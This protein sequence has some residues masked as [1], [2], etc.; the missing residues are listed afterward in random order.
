MGLPSAVL[1]EEP[2]P[3]AAPGGAADRHSA[4]GRR[5]GFVSRE[6]I[7]GNMATG[8][9]PF[10]EVMHDQDLPNWS[11]DSVDDR[12]NNM[13]W[14]GQQ[15]KANR[16]SEKNKK[17]FGVASD[18]RVTNAIS[19]ESSPGVG[20][21]RT[22]IP[23]TFPHSRYMTQMSVPEQAE[24]EKLKQRINFSDLDQRSIGSDSQ[25]RATA[26]NNKRQLSENRKPF[27]FLPMQI[28][29]NKSK[30]ATASLP[31]R[32]MTTSAQCK[33]LFAS[34][35]SNDLLQ[36]CQ[37][38]EEDGRGEP[39]MESS[40]IVSRL[41]QIRDYIT[42]ASSMREDLVEKNERSANVERL[43]HLIEHLKEQ[44]KSYM[45]F[46]QKILARE[47][48]EEDVRTVD[49]AVGSGSVAESTSLNADV[50]SEASDTT[51]RDRKS[52]V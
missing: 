41:V 44:E 18:K 5:G 14:G 15:K 6:L 51:A 10:E 13:E 34:A 36:N 46:L 23:H 2:L 25:G 16:S 42:K 48:E 19:P 12:L 31:K 43:T 33:E 35:L 8:G 50:Q 30:D 7:K 28:N 32:E 4:L 1:E 47:N 9:G 27:N 40:Q 21:R 17:K 37:V 26:A 20:R 3:A 29:T 22:K 39:A 49:S 52:V 24:L 38:S 11:N 45:K